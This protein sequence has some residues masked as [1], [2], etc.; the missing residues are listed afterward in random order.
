MA[1]PSPIVQNT[2]QEKQNPDTRPAWFCTCGRGNPASISHCA[3]CSQLRPEEKVIRQLA[4]VGAGLGRGGGY[5]ERNEITE[6]RRSDDERE[7]AQ[8]GFDAYG[9]RIFKDEE[10]VAADRGSAAAAS[11][12][13]RQRKALERLRNPK[14]RRPSLSPPRTRTFRDETSRSRERRKGGRQGFILSGGVR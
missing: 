7:S 2:H 5:F 10:A 3:G 12:A 4:R 1:R 9:R 6:S 14:A 8:K 13:E 11:R